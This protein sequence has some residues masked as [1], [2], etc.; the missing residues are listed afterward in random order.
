MSFSSLVKS[1]FLIAV[2]L[3]NSSTIYLS[4]YNT[5]S[6]FIPIGVIVL[7]VFL[8]AFKYSIPKILFEPD[9]TLA[10]LLI[11]FKYISKA[12]SLAFGKELPF[13]NS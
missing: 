9:I 3:A 2:A 11:S 1:I 7:L 12:F 5:F 6:L 4:L 10:Y 13:C 8:N